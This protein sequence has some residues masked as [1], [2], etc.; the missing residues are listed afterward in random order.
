[1]TETVGFIGLGRMGRPMA[2]N[3]CRKGFRVIAH[4]INRAAVAE[5]ELLQA[6]GAADVAEVAAQSDIIATM[7][8]NP[9]VVR[10]IIEAL[11]ASLPRPGPDPSSST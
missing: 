6:R 1:M 4:D 3:L 9:A 5:L 10:E 11:P 8:P 7:L 2:A